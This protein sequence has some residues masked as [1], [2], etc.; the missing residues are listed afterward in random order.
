MVFEICEQ[1][2]RHTRGLQ[3]YTHHYRRRTAQMR[4]G[5]SFDE[6][7]GPSLYAELKFTA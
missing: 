7:I 5:S 3:Y 6:F 4:F 2:D 1:T